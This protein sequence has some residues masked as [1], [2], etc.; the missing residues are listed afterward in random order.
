MDLG[1]LTI[2]GV[3]V[4]STAAELNILDTVT[5]TATELNIMDGSA[6]TPG[7]TAVAAGDGIVTNDGGTMQT[8]YGSHFLNLF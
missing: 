5:T 8:N 2:G 3:A 4:T 1:S 7:T 6:T